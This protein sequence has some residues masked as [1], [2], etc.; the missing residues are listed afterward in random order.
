[1]KDKTNTLTGCISTEP[2]QKDITENKPNS[3]SNINNRTMYYL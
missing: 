1:M 3:K 2:R